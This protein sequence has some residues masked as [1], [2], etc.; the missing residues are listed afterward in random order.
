MFLLKDRIVRAGVLAQ[1][2][3]TLL[4]LAEDLGSAPSAHVAAHNSP[5]SQGN[6]APSSDLIRH[7][8]HRQH[9]YLHGGRTLIH[10]IKE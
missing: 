2:L 4:V 8:A 3:A 9:T 1:Q 10:I 5:A 6:L 7:W